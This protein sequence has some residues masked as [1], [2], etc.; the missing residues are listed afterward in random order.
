MQGTAVASYGVIANISYVAISIF[1]GISQGTQP[2]ISESY[3][4]GMQQQAK[5]LLKS[6]MGISILAETSIISC[7]WAV[8]D[9]LIGIFNSERNEL[10]LQYAHS[11]LRLYFLGF[12]FAGINIML[13]TYFSATDM[14]ISAMIG[15]VLRCAAAIILCA[16]V[17]ARLFGMTGVWLSFLASELITFIV[18]LPIYRQRRPTVKATYEK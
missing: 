5:F 18:I 15:S 1:N 6:G 2:L 3:G 16:V 4:N 9:P 8:T 10:L 12:I 17:L 13:I 11:G 7:I 14:A